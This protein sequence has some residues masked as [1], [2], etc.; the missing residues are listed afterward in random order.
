MPW[1][2]RASVIPTAGEP[3]RGLTDR[4]IGKGRI[5]CFSAEADFVSGAVIG[6]IGVATLSQVEKP[7]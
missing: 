7:A 2:S 3:I 5:V 1:S 4:Q 6:A